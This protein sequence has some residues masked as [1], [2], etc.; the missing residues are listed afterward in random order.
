[1]NQE[2]NLPQGVIDLLVAIAASSCGGGRPLT[3]Q[4]RRARMTAY[5][6]TYIDVDVPSDCE[7]GNWADG[8]LD[9]KPLVTD[10]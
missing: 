7:P 6:P 10:Q 5:S 1:M 3:L 4:A 8:P 9:I 2:L